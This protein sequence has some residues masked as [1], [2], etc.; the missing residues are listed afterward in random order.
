MD[1]DLDNKIQ[2]RDAV[3]QER[4]CLVFSGR[5]VREDDCIDYDGL[6]VAL[7]WNEDYSP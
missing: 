6:L 1:D 2:I 3:I 5:M 7:P 4:D